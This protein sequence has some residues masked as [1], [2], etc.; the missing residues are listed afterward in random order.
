MTASLPGLTRRLLFATP[1]LLHAVGATKPAALRVGVATYSLRK[2]SRAQAISMLRE[3]GVRTLSVKEFHLPYKDSAEALA[4]GRREFDQADLE[5]ASGG[6][7]VTY[8]EEDGMLRRYFEYGRICR[9]PMLI[10]MPTKRQLLLIEKLAAEFDIR[11]AIHNHGPEDKNFPTPKSVYDAI[12]GLDRRIGVC[13]DVGHSARA[14]VDVVSSIQEC[15]SRLV[16]VHIKDL[17]ALG[18]HTD[19][20]VGRGVLPIPAILRALVAARYSGCVN[21]EYEAEPE[22]PVPGMRSSLAYIRGVLAGLGASSK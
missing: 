13:I 4:A 19:C 10:M 22:N 9:F 2:F 15:R 5:L 17:R 21:L 20:E 8:R 3:L 12:R 18:G 6:V 1:A 11:V 7:V 14:G 16:D